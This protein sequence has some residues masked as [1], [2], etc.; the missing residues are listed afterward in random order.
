MIS[1]VLLAALAASPTITVEFR[2]NLRDGLQEIARK[3][4]LN[5]VASGDLDHDAV[6]Q[7]KDIT[8]EEALTSVAEAYEL[9]LTQKGSLWVIKPATAVAAAPPIP[10]LAPI[11][12]VAPV[13]PV[14]L[15][16]PAAAVDEAEA[17]REHAEAMRDEAE[18]LRERAEELRDAK[19]EEI[20]AAREQARAHIEAAKAQAGSDKGVVNMNG[21]VV[22]KANERVESAISY[23]GPVTIEKNARVDGDVVSFGGD[24]VLEENARVEGDAVAFGGKVIKAEGAKVKG[25]EVSFGSSGLGSVMASKAVKASRPSHASGG[26]K[27][28]SAIASFFAQFAVLFGAGFLLMMFAPQRMKTIEAEM[29]QA[30]A[31]NGVAGFLAM[32]SSIP[33]TIFL[34]VTLI[35]IPVALAFWM[36]AGLCTLMGLVAVANVV[37]SKVPVARLRRTQAIALAVG[38]LVMLL[39]ARIPV[40]GP[41]LMSVG[42][43]VSLGAIVRTRLGQRGQG[44]PISTSSFIDSTPSQP[45]A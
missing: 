13:A 24:V 28:G 17:A 44:M 12:P 25:E 29:K 10:P 8:A 33:L 35:G 34:C 31:K 37:G 21:P 19:R 38:L 5:L 9:Q 41:L 26:D 22:I 14:P 39:V 7:L 20:D 23:G 15:K 36:L 32:L 4:G 16:S 30:P 18:E 2:G 42:I 27:G 43:F 3:G 45:A 6:I 1:L 40:A 11:P